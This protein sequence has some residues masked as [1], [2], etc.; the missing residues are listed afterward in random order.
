MNVAMLITYDH[1]V[2]LVI[3]I[4]IVIVVCELDQIKGT[5]ELQIREPNFCSVST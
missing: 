2:L 4:V 1:D 5:T 3:M